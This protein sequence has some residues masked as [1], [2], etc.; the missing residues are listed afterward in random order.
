MERIITARQFESGN[1]PN[2]YVN[3]IRELNENPIFDPATKPYT[4]IS[5]IKSDTTNHGWLFE[6]GDQYYIA[7]Q[8]KYYLQTQYVSIFLSDRKQTFDAGQQPLAQ[9]VTYVDIEAAVDRFVKEELGIE[10]NNEN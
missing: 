4:F 1:I 5:K 10:L 9:Y 8:H 2:K 3:Q 7:L 6:V